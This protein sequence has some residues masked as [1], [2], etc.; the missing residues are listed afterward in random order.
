MQRDGGMKILAFFLFAAGLVLCAEDAVFRLDLNGAPGTVLETSD[1]NLLFKPQMWKKPELRKSSL[2]GEYAVPDKGAAELRFTLSSPVGGAMN[3]EFAGAWNDDAGKRRFLRLAEVRVNDAMIPEG[4]FINTK[5]MRDGK[6]IPSGFQFRG[7]PEY[8]AAGGAEGEP[9]VRINH[10]NRLILPLAV[11]AGEKYRLMIRLSAEPLPPDPRTLRKLL[12]FSEN[13]RIELPGKG[14]SAEVRMVK[15]KPDL[16]P[17]GSTIWLNG[18]VPGFSPRSAA[19]IVNEFEH[20]REEAFY[21]GFA[22]DWWME[23]QL[24]GA[25]LL[26][27]LAKGNGKPFDLEQHKVLLPVKKGKNVLKVKVLSGS[28]GWFF[29]F[30]SP[31]PHVPPKVFREN[32]EWR[33]VDMESLEVKPGTALDLS[34]R[35][36]APAG[37]FGRP[38]IGKGGVLVFE[39]A[40]EKTARYQGFSSGLPQ[41]LWFG[42]SKEQF[43]KNAVRIASAI[44]RQGYNLFRDHGIDDWIMRGSQT[45]AEFDAEM[46]DRWDFLFAEMKKQGI[47]W[48]H[49]V[50]SFG[51]YENDRERSRTFRSRD[52]HKL[53][54]TIGRDL[55][56]QRFKLGAEKFLNHVNPYTG[57]AWKDDPALILVEFY[58]ESYSGFGR[59]AE[60]EKWFPKEYEYFH[61]KWSEWLRKRFSGRP[62]AERPPEL[63]GAGLQNPPRFKTYDVSPG[64]IAETVRF[65]IECAEE[66]NRWCSKVIRDAGFNG[67]VTQNG[68]HP[69]FN[70]AAL[71]DTVPFADCHVYYKHP[72]NWARPGSQVGQESAAGECASYFRGLNAQRLYGRPFGV[73]EFNHCFWNPYQHEMP[74]VFTAYAALQGYS[75]L[76]IHEMAVMLDGFWKRPRLGPFQVAPN[77]VL[78]AGEFLGNAFFLRGDVAPSPHRIM[79]KVP[80]SYLLSKDGGEAVSA[81]QSKLALLAGFGT[82]FP[83]RPLPEGLPELPEPDYQLP[84]SGPSKT[85]LHGWFSSV[86]ASA[87][88]AF[89]LKDCVEQ[90]R[91]KGILNAENRT[92]VSRGIFQSDTGEIMLNAPARR[93]QVDTPRSQAVALPAG[94][95][96]ELSA[97]RVEKTTADVLAAATSVDGRPL[98]SSARIVLILATAVVNREMQV[99]GQEPAKL[100]AL[101]RGPALMRT[102]SFE[103]KLKNPKPLVCY[104]LRADGVR[105]E[106]IPVVREG[107]NIKIAVD[108]AALQK[109][110]AVFFELTESR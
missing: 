55:E 47:S 63:R 69:V 31:R 110:P 3:M 102:G 66:M 74:L 109:G 98:N 103:L 75:T 88:D 14:G 25:T 99:D 38:V 43:R 41:E 21:A 5:N 15:K 81:E 53:M 60:L 19:L 20:D 93:I 34:A 39:K 83:D 45:A 16:S 90:L 6:R 85:Y 40:P 106:R 61:R 97:F 84:V 92:D 9:A 89:P 7:K 1:S 104:S 68:Y 105:L 23:V 29:R 70:A 72:S 52:M 28:G 46:L 87:D 27:T 79:L 22:A 12:P 2:Y 17:D 44:R 4:G 76:A 91:R 57:I 30:G 100:V 67:L 96:A 77:P 73:G 86:S 8:L 94:D 80:D 51:L 48:Q 35:I 64:L 42:C 65:R 62:D 71:W 18:L 32:A 26:S 107:G 50:F 10:D 11:K 49:V 54:M 13:W 95:R 58:N 37:K 24:N 82:A 33:A 59:I 108:T 101:S 56:R 36:D 78:R